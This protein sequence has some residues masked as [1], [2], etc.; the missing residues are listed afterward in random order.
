MGIS[1]AVAE[2]VGVCQKRRVLPDDGL[3]RHEHGIEAVRPC[4]R[5]HT[6]LRRRRSVP[7]L[8]IGV[9]RPVRLH[10]PIL[11]RIQAR[12]DVRALSE[13]RH[14]IGTG[15]V[16]TRVRHLGRVALDGPTNAARRLCEGNDHDNDDA[17]QLHACTLGANR[18]PTRQRG[19]SRRCQSSTRRSKR[20]IRAL[21]TRT[22]RVPVP[23]TSHST[24]AV[25]T[26]PA[27]RRK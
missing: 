26:L 12:K 22:V 15:Y 25:L 2:C 5:L 27:L 9:L 23:C 13:I 7:S 17:R 11:G 14:G 6:R 18:T 20:P 10:D 1:L 3:D 21:P 8:R 4:A 16:I 19:L 24:V